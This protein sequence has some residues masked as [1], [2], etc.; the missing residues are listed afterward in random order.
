M[1]EDQEMV[2]GLREVIGKGKRENLM[3]DWRE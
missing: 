2:S 1:L 3:G